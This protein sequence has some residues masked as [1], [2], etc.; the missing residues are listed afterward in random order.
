MTDESEGQTEDWIEKFEAEYAYAYYSGS[1]LPSFAKVSGIPSAILID[2]NGKVVWKG[3]PSSLNG[4]TIEAHLEGSLPVPLYD[5]PKEAASVKKAIL[6]DDLEKALTEAKE[7]EAE[8]VELSAE[9]RAAVEAMIS[10]RVEQVKAAFAR[11]DYLTV[12]VD[13]ETL[14]DALGDLPESAEIADFLEQIKNNSA[15]K[16]VIKAQRKIAEIRDDMEDM[17]KAIEA[18]RAIGKLRKLLEDIEGTYAETQARELM[19]QLDKLR[20]TLR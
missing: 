8:G 15:M 10:S 16:D 17:R 2:P 9:I 7:I 12:E 4:R 18:D 11:G 13:G 5:F 14:V 1:D 19:D 20:L 3:H 6:K